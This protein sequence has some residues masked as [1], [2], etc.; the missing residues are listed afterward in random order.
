MRASGSFKIKPN[1][2]K[3][4][5]Q[6]PN[7]ISGRVNDMRVT[8]KYHQFD[9]QSAPITRPVL[10]SQSDRYTLKSLQPLENSSH[11][12]DFDVDMCVDE[13]FKTIEVNTIPQTVEI[14]IKAAL[15]AQ[16]VIFWQEI[17]NLQLLYSPTLKMTCQH[18]DGIVGNTLYTRKLTNYS[19]AKEHP[20]FDPQIDAKFCPNNSPIIAFPIFDC[21]N[22]ILCVCIAIRPPGS[23]PFTKAMENFCNWFAK[24]IKF[25]TRYVKPKRDVDTHLLDVTQIQR[26]EQ[27]LTGTLP[28]ISQFFQCRQVEIWKYDKSEQVMSRFSSVETKVTPEESGIAGNCLLKNTVINCARCQLHGHYNPISDGNNNEAVLAFPV[29]ESAA[30]VSYCVILR[31]PQ[32][33]SIFTVED[34]DLLKKLAPHY[35]LSLENS[36]TFSLADDCIQCDLRERNSFCALLEVAELLSSQTDKD[37]LLLTIMEKGRQLTNADRCSLFIVNEDKDKLI[38]SFQNGLSNAITIPITKGIAGHT[39]TERTI[40]NISDAYDCDF[41]DPTTD[42]ET[43][44]KTRSILSVP[45][46]NNRSE[47]IG[48]TEMI[49]KNDHKPFTQWDVNVIQIFNVFVGISLENVSLYKDAREKGDLL[50]NLLDVSFSITKSEDVHRLLR[51]ILSNARKQIN[52]ECGSLFLRDETDT[53]TSYI[54]DGG[55]LPPNKI[56]SSGIVAHYAKTKRGIIDND[57]YHSPDF[58]RS[59]DIATGFKTKSILAVPVVDGRGEIIGVVEM[60]NKFDNSFNNKDMEVVNNFAVFC[61]VAID[62]DRLKGIATTGSIDIE[63]TKWISDTERNLVDEVPAKLRLTEDQQKLILSRN[64]F[65]PD[66]KGINHIRE[67]FFIWSMFGILKDFNI[68]NELFFRFIYKVSSMYNDTPYHNWMHVCDVTAFVAFELKTSGFDKQMTP[69]EKLALFA[70]VVCH[71]LD[72]EGLNNSYNIKAQTPLGMLYKDTSVMETHHLSLAIEIITDDTYNIIH[73]LSEAETIEFWQMMIK[74][75]YATD[76][77][78]HFETIKNVKK[79]IEDGVFSLNNIEHKRTA[80]SLIL[81]VADIS[82]ASRPFEIADKWV[83][84]L[85]KEFFRQGDLEKEK[86]IGLSS[87]NNDREHPDKPKSQ[88]GFINFVCLPLYKVVA[89]IIPALQVNVDGLESNLTVWNE[90][91][92]KQNKLA[93]EKQSQN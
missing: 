7:L 87:P 83:D 10:S 80:I 3:P 17:Y 14:Y 74:N 77:A 20:S 18:T 93:Q 54:S 71:D 66:F 82:N 23:N 24:K 55:N 69:L 70:S 26:T 58:N 13:L 40:M 45:I 67:Q 51:D 11:D 31:G 4:S 60:I 46:Y 34:E 47:I 79:L 91:G 2:L 78:K 37:K 21:N 59:V 12:G 81:K 52:C 5:P 50:R 29:T 68:S 32:N 48:V 15:D 89:T 64:Y 41:F 57:V 62:N 16:T 44:Y 19:S 92:E 1:P 39:Y 56:L 38:T 88:I 49:N 53:L 75:I 90:L 85:N 25:F 28:I 61:S 72:H 63:L 42:K 9:N 65:S 76:M 27:F 86:G 43:G 8:P 84:I 35:V 30:N 36:N 73:S 22:S 6:L 33:N